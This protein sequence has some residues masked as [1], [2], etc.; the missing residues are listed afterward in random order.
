MHECPD[1]AWSLPL[2]LVRFP[3]GDLSLRAA[4]TLDVRNLRTL[5]HARREARSHNNIRSPFCRLRTSHPAEA[6]TQSV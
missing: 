3:F 1:E 2:T 6:D 5:P 4:V